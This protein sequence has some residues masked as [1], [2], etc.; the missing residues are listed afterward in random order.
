[1][2]GW[3]PNHITLI[4][5]HPLSPCWAVLAEFAPHTQSHYKSVHINKSMVNIPVYRRYMKTP[6]DHHVSAP[7]C[8]VGVT[9]VVQPGSLFPSTTTTQIRLHNAC[10]PQSPAKDCC[11]PPLL[12][13]CPLTNGQP[14]GWDVG[15]G[16]KCLPDPPGVRRLTFVA[17]NIGHAYWT[18][19][20]RRLSA[21]TAG[22]CTW[23]VTYS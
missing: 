4:S 18:D 16:R 15:T 5:M 3:R 23:M 7:R 14:A 19:Q 17:H 8:G 21:R 1:M 13:P 20:Q 12:S 6:I 22:Y 10:R 9:D 11:L 2:K